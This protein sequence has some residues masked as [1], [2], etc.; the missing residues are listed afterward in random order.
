MEDLSYE[1]IAEVM[2]K[3]LSS[4][5]SLMHRAKNNLKKELYDYYNS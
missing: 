1:Q 2:Q 4:I 5:E 3:S